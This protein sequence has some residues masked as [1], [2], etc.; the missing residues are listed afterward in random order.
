MV[1]DTQFVRGAERLGRR[2]AT[3]RRTLNLPDLTDEIGQLLLNR[4]LRRF[5]AEVTPDGI[6]WEPLKEST[7]RRKRQ[8][9][10][11]DRQKLQRTDDMRSA[12]RLIRGGI[13][14]AMFTNTGAGVRIAITDPKIAEYARVQNRGSYDGRIPARRFLGIGRLDVKAVDSFLRRKAKQVEN[15]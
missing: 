2:I 13:T 5:K 11:G 9:G 10:Y 3:I 4:T 15:T 12:I 6:P 8:L 14:G 7:I 1:R